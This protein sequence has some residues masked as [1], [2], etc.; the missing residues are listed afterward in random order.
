MR[1]PKVSR[2]DFFAKFRNKKATALVD[3]F[4]NE[5]VD[6]DDPLF[7][8]YSRKEL[9]ERR[10]SQQMAIPDVNN[11]IYAR[12][13][14]VT[15]GL[16]PYPSTGAWTI[17][18]VTHL[19]RR[20]SF[21]VKKSDIDALL[22]LSPS[23]AVDALLNIAPPT[24]PSATPLNYYQATLADSGGI[25]LG[26]SWTSNNLTFVN[27]NDGTNDYYREL[28]LKYWSWGLCLDSSPTIREKMTHFWYHFIPI[29][30]EEIR[31]IQVNASTMSHDY[32][33]LLRTNALGNFKTLIKA[34]AKTPAMLIYLGNQ[35]STAT[36]PNE[37]FARELMELFTIGKVPQNYTE[38]DVKAASK[39]LSGWRVPSFTTAYPFNP[40]FNSSYHNQTNK[41]F[42]AAYFA[43]TTIANQ[44]GANGANEFDLFFDMLFD[45]QKVAISQYICRR[46]YRFFVYYDIDTNVE[47]NVIV[48][49]AALLVTNNW[50]MQP[51]IS[52][53]FK[54]EH[55]FDLANRGV[56]IKSPFDFVAGTLR[57]FGVNTT[58]A[59][60]ATQV[61]NQYAIWAALNNYSANYLEQSMGDIPNVSGWKA[62]YQ[63][64]TYYQ[65]WVNSNT[66]QRRS[67]LLTTFLGGGLYT[68]NLPL[69]IDVI[70]F[71][72]QFPNATIQDP[73]L[74]IDKIIQYLLTQDL[75]TQFKTDTK[76]ATLLGNQITNGYWTTAW[77]NYT[78]TPTNTTYLNT[79]TTRLK[80]LITTLV[81]LA[82]NQLM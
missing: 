13:G 32:M 56:M 82:E 37:N 67:S 26:D 43:G 74:L 16:A 10:Y 14:N 71:V 2:R 19:L 27:P 20:L 50:N 35:Y 45:K 75:P 77:N 48:P 44:T 69:K 17:W 38:D 11:P 36:V 47:A 60:G 81:Q 80:S 65:N 58:A 5:G 42:S 63:G 76:V 25:A 52:T 62:Y 31:N 28:S 46:L 33:A 54:S 73:D 21:G 68:G 1:K 22:L 34:I 61:A 7:D 41:V 29:N 49:L 53:L 18:E 6:S 23:A 79:V 9:G 12:V 51:I 78:G 15:S 24:A 3:N 30:F 72:Q 66:I 59:T 70:A 4:G 40:G 39:V 64:P 57:T 8:K 55:F